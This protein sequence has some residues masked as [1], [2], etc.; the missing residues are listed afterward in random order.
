MQESTRRFLELMEKQN[1][2]VAEVREAEEARSGVVEPDYIRLAREQERR[3]KYG[4]LRAR[5]H[6]GKRPQRVRRLFGFSDL[7]QND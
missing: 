4:E 3:E 6:P 2:M 1:R 7:S 5:E